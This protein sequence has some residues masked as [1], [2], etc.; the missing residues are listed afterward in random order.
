M[1][2][3]MLVVKKYNNAFHVGKYETIK[4]VVVD[5]KVLQKEIDRMEKFISDDKTMQ[6]EIENVY[7]DCVKIK[8]GGNS[9]ENNEHKN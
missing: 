4:A 2:K 7:S 6:L 9:G 1:E 3:Y 5:K 8:G